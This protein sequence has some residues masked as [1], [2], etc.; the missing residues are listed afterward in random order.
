MESGH[1]S[2][3]S[4]SSAILAAFNNYIQ[5]YFV[6]RDAEKTF[7]LYSNDFSCFGTGTDEIGLDPE[8]AIRL[9]ERD[10][11]QAPNTI[12]VT[13]H[14]TNV[15][16]YSETIGLVTANMSIVT[17]VDDEPVRM[18]GLR[19]SA[20]F[21]LERDGWLVVH[22]NM[23]L[24]TEFQDEGES[25]PLKELATRNRLLEDLVAERTADLKAQNE[26]LEDALRQ[27]EVL[28]G[29]LPICAS[30]KR[31]RDDRGEWQQVEVYLRDHSEARFSHG[32]CPTCMSEN[33]SD[34]FDD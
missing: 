3:E 17:E 28:T 16:A 2:P 12:D 10:L 25:Y 31:I 30:C 27:V 23:S 8:R 6:D 9:I 15:H 21:R 33:V 7:S 29:I 20:V 32:V 26:K 22:T 14:S 4:L 18:S 5:V 24:P 1:R 11:E 19:L 34:L 13:F